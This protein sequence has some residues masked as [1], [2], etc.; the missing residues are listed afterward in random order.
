MPREIRS[1]RSFFVPFQGERLIVQLQVS[2][3]IGC[4]HIL[5]Y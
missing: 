5:I 2:V 4:V 1:K 3:E